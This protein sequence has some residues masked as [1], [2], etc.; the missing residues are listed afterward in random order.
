M[1]AIILHRKEGYVE[2]MGP[3]VKEEECKVKKRRGRSAVFSCVQVLLLKVACVSDIEHCH[4][5]TRRM[6]LLIQ[7]KQNVPSRRVGGRSSYAS[8]RGVPI[9]PFKV[10]CASV[11]GPRL[12]VCAA[13][14]VRDVRTMWYEVDFASNMVRMNWCQEE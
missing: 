7:K 6:I 13:R 3:P 11:M 14:V 8:L 1:D 12:I 2:G 10:E 4:P 5:S 9:D